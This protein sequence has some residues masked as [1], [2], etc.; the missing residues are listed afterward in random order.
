ML[1]SDAFG[2]SNVRCDTVASTAPEFQNAGQQTL[3][4][5]ET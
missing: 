4:P 5:N 2:Q 3:S 1:T